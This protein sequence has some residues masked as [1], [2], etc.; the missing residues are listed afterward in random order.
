V[1]TDERQVRL[2]GVIRVVIGRISGAFKLSGQLRVRCFGDPGDFIDVSRLVLGEREE[3]SE[4]G[5]LYEVADIIAG[6]REELRVR[7]IG[8]EDR[9]AAEALKGRWVFAYASELVPTED[10]EYYGYELIGCTV[11]GEDGEK[12]GVVRDIWSAAGQDLLVVAD[13]RGAEH[14]IPMARSILREV[15]IEARRIGITEIPG[16][17]DT[18]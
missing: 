15:D 17:L 1:S 10:E 12:I 9:N 6:R 2:P 4:A 13:G 7:L 8:V 3:D 14:L 5:T 16:L 11:E 18:G